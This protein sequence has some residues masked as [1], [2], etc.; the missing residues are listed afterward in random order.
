VI[1]E[2]VVET[3]DNLQ[4]LVE[5]GEDDGRLIVYEDANIDPTM[6]RLHI[7]SPS[8]SSLEISG[9]AS[10]KLDG[11]DEAEF[12]LDSC[13]SS[14]VSITG[15]VGMFDIETSGSASTRARTLTAER[16]KVVA[17]TVILRTPTSTGAVRAPS[18]AS[19]SF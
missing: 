5:L 16:V 19:D 13:G 6:L 9:S 15:D 7:I 3:D 8:L 11:I 12:E 14:D 10:A 17:S 1:V 2:V 18:F 4:D